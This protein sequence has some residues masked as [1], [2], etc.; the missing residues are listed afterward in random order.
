[1]GKNSDTFEV[2][3]PVAPASITRISMDYEKENL[4]GKRVG[5]FWNRKP[6]GEIVLS[7]FGELLKKRY[8][9]IKVEWLQGKNDPAQSAPE[10]TLK[11]AGEKCEFV[12]IAAAD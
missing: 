10:S 11:E 7:E 1:M 3:N 5:L 9:D 2:L 6:N 8:S 4:E 12:I